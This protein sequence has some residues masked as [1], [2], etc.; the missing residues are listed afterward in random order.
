MSVYYAIVNGQLVRRLFVGPM[1]QV[2]EAPKRSTI[3]QVLPDYENVAETTLV[4]NNIKEQQQAIAKIGD[5]AETNTNTV[6]MKRPKVIRR[7]RKFV[8]SQAD[9]FLATHGY[10]NSE[11]RSLT[12]YHS[13]SLMYEYSRVK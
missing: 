13:N 10:W 8:Y 11:K 5:S 12:R 3:A 2:V 4:V 6:S 1:P 7:R 9:E